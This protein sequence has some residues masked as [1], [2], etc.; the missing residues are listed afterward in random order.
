MI[1]DHIAGFLRATMTGLL[2]HYPFPTFTTINVTLE[3]LSPSCT[4]Y[5]CN[6]YTKMIF[7]PGRGESVVKFN[8]VRSAL[9]WDWFS[10]TFPRFFLCEVLSWIGEHQSYNRKQL[11]VSLFWA[12]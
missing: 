6:C 9:R 2:T 3:I 4:N 8:A 5:M 1:E 10:I 7:I 12:L 11:V